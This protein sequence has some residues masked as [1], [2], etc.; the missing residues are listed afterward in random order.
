MATL[1]HLNGPPAVGKSAVARELTAR[2]PLA[3]NLDID[4]IRVRLG[5]WQ[6]LGE[7]KGVA[8]SLGFKLAEWHLAED[9]DVVL[10][11]LLV[12]Q[13][14]VAD[15]AALAERSGA[16]FQEVVLHGS[17]DTCLQ[18]LASDRLGAQEHPRLV[19]DDEELAR[20]IAYCV[21]AMSE[22]TVAFP[23]AIVIDAAGD[24]ESIAAAVEA[25]LGSAR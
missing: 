17:V 7:S 9:Q 10:P 23:H 3:L 24:L 25:A 16:T 19:Y 18:R 2:R 13:E 21:G 15:L 8:R 14:V 11:Q 4:A 12:R 6:E 5:Q 22:I 20:R 1:I